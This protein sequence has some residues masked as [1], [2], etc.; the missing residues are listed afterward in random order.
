ME[1]SHDATFHLILYKCCTSSVSERKTLSSLS[2]YAR[3]TGIK[4]IIWTLLESGNPTYLCF[5]T[6]TSSAYMATIQSRA[7]AR[8]YR[9]FLTPSLHRRFTNAALLTLVLCY[10]EA[11]WMGQ[12]NSRSTS[13]VTSIQ[14]LFPR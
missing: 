9:D 3:A 10:V 13:I 8:P 4:K 14:V 12:W 1:K 5:S 7:I 11:V 2:V 6:S